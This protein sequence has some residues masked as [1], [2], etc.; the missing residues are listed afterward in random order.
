MDLGVI[1]SYEL[2]LD[3]ALKDTLKTHGSLLSSV[4]SHWLQR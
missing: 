2:H 1:S 4:K 3:S